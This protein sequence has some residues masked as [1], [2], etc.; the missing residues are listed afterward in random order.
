MKC[1]DKFIDNVL[2]LCDTCFIHDKIESVR[3]NM[4]R[5][6]EIIENNNSVDFILNYLEG[7]VKIANEKIENILNA[8]AT[9]GNTFREN[10]VCLFLSWKDSLN[11][12][13][14]KL[15][16][17]KKKHNK[18]M[19]SKSFN[20]L[21]TSGIIAK[22]IEQNP[23]KG[24]NENNETLYKG[25]FDEWLKTN[26]GWNQNNIIQYHELLNEGNFFEFLKEYNISMANDLIK[27][28]I[29]TIK[30]NTIN[31]VQ[32][33]SDI[34]EL[35][36]AMKILG[37]NENYNNFFTTS[38]KTSHI[39]SVLIEY[40]LTTN[41]AWEIVTNRKESFARNTLFTKNVI[42]PILQYL[43]DTKFELPNSNQ[44]VNKHFDFIWF[45]V[46]LEFAKGNVQPLY[47]KHKQNKGCFNTITKEL[48]FE[49]KHRPYFSDT[50]NNT[51]KN[52]KNIY[53]NLNKM[54]LIIDYCKENNIKINEDFSSQFNLLSAKK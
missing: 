48:K 26:K 51:T 50:L 4:I 21:Y 46:G 38:P 52:D 43:R 47:A 33:E 23:N 53:S 10:R 20:E 39:K 40:Q 29:D 5:K 16:N 25:D 49:L 7:K 2:E 30:K 11:F 3:K 31:K 15:I 45:K 28:E 9:G 32:L 18:T 1:K 13:S 42:E 19:D 44:K 27:N 24:V 14:I 35:E 36:I 17:L 54:S 8:E 37:L 6:F 41:D 22:Q 12:Y 34:K